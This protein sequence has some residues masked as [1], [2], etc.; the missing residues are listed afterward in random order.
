LDRWPAAD[1]C[2]WQ[3]ALSAGD[4]FEDRGPAA[5]WSQGSKRTVLHAY[6]RWLGHLAGHDPDS[7]GH[8]PAARITQ[9]AVR[10]YVA[11]LDLTITP[12]GT[13][14][15]V[16]HLYDAARVM[17]PERDFAWLREIARRLARLVIP[18]NKRPRMVSTLEL[19]NLG[20]ALMERA[21]IDPSLDAPQKAILYRDGLII[22]LLASRALRRRT[23]AAITI[24]GTLV[25]S[26][27][28][29]M[30]VFTECDTKSRQPFETTVPQDLVP[31][32]ERYLAVHRPRIF[33]AGQHAGLWASE[34]GRPMTPEAIYARVCLHTRAAF[35]RTINPHLF[36]DCLATDIAIHDPAHVRVAAHMLGHADL[37]TTE[38]HYNQ[39]RAL[40]A[41]RRHQRRILELRRKLQDHGRPT[42]RK[43]P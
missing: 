29:Y 26:G 24:D 27:A 12:A 16:K 31:K 23:L 35:G 38:R 8:D 11:A 30:L 34:K 10:A 20:H 17:F 32:V 25:R 19:D 33:G 1:R 43:E 3:R 14:N 5:R 4:I 28:G 22:A 40:E 36:R 6:R 42:R 41:G 39:A 15:Y 9:D 2:A 13:Y 7:L 37:R 21:D 18:R